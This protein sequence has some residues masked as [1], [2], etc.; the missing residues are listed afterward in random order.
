MK[1]RAPFIWT[2]QQAID[3]M[4][5]LASF[6]GTPARTDGKNRWQL[7]RR[8]IKLTEA[9]ASSNVSITMD[10][11]YQLYVNGCR[12]GRGPVRSTPLDQKYDQYDIA[13]YLNVGR[14]VVG[15]IA[16]VFGEDKSWYE[17]VKGMW[18]PSF[19]DGALWVDGDVVE[20]DLEWRTL[21]CA[22]WNS[23][24]PAANHG[25]GFIEQF[26]A[27]Q[28]PDNWLDSDFDDAG[29]DNVHILETGGGGPEAFFGGLRNVPFP[30]L[31]K[32]PI[33]P[34]TEESVG[35]GEPYWIKGL[36]TDAELPLYRRPY[37]EQFTALPDGAVT[38]TGDGWHIRTDG[39]TGVIM[40]F[41]LGKL[42]TGTISFELE[43]TGGEVL[44]FVVNEQ[45]PGEWET[46]GPAADARID[47]QELLGLNAHVTSYTA[48]SGHQRYERF[49]WQAVKWLQISIRNAPDGVTLRN[50]A[51]VQ[52]H[53]PVVEAGR[54]AASEAMLTQLWS[55]GAYTLKLC[56]HDGW[57]DCPSREQRQWLGDAT[58]ENLV[59][60]AAFGPSIIPL[61]AK[62]L[63]DVAA[64]QRTDGLTQMFAPGNHSTNGLLIPDWTLQWILNARDHLRW[65]GDLETV[66]AI[67]PSIQKA[68][69]WFESL[70]NS[71]HLVADMP[72]WHFMDWAGVGRHGE[73]LTLNAQLAGCFDAAA[74]MAD[75]LEMPRAAI[76]Y[77]MRADAICTALN[78]R[79][80]DTS[81]Q[82]YV[83]CVDPVTGAQ[84]PRVSQHG[85]AAMVLW[86]RAPQ[87]RWPAIMERIG[88]ATRLTFTAAPPI[89]P[90]GEALDPMEGVVLANTFYSHFVQCAF[91]RAGRSDL[92]LDLLRRR[93]G[94]ML[95]RGA[96]TLWESFEP[97]A[98]LCHGFSATP[99]YQLV[100]GLLGLQPD[101][102]GFGSLRIAPLPTQVDWLE[103]TLPTVNGEINARMER[104]GKRWTMLATFPTDMPF[105]WV[106]P[107]GF[108]LIGGPL[109]GVG[110][111]HRWVLQ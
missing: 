90:T 93:Y 18:Q 84:E 5:H 68:L 8:V 95:A 3:P 23:D 58:V 36:K 103:A 10:G 6:F 37:E 71:N 77:R 13:P 40:L 76:R 92:L 22:A 60:H 66:E 2:S 15:V 86:G 38:Q 41:D 64:S 102:D 73:A 99:T 85:N 61:N 42:H 34:L 97:T 109:S 110:G 31:T 81:R 78:A 104:Q 96:T 101:S 7:F 47:R 70:L 25:L 20:S 26:D 44:D 53:Y 79:H 54:F 11:R 21:S 98:S 27:R 24:A 32:N 39:D 12:V 80:W 107:S 49:L 19:G 87:D 62:F 30:I 108:S 83:D 52:T 14:N 50:V 106:T 89:A 57:E 111:T 28:F 9:P 35:V 4:G 105:Q 51:V 29:W 48:R 74:A 91:V 55:T 59:G 88:D 46:G 63:R 65:A 16:H 56:M 69:A 100:T 72:Y 17:S 82:I 67:F 43:A 33:P 1:Q 75:A 45:L 94:P